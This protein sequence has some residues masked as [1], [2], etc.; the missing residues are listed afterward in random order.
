MLS[1]IINLFDKNMG[2]VF[3]RCHRGASCR[4]ASLQRDKIKTQVIPVHMGSS[5][6][7]IMATECLDGK[8][9]YEYMA[10]NKNYHNIVQ[11]N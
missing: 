3:I 9:L 5:K 4:A 1:M 11:N 10:N 7:Y 8:K 2:G 6:S